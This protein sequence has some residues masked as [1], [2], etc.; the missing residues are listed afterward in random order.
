M[1]PHATLLADGACHNAAM[2][3]QLTVDEALTRFLDEQQERLA[4]RTFR[5]YEDVVDLLRDC[6]NG[7]G[8]NILPKVDYDRWRRAY[9]TGDEDAFCT[10][11]S[12]DHIVDMLD[13]FLGYFMVRKVI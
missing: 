1:R 9:D 13:E 11:M 12:A 3:M 4:P 10:E 2:T 5:N 7:Y 8:P 6:L